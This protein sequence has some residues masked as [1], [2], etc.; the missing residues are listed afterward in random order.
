MN[1]KED[2]ELQKENLQEEFDNKKRIAMWLSVIAISI[3]IIGMI[4]TTVPKQNTTAKAKIYRLSCIT[5]STRKPLKVCEI[6][7][8]KIH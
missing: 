8:I 4:A 2:E 3:G 1:I 5:S 7:Y 6:K